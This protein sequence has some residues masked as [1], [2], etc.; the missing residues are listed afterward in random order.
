MKRFILCALLSLAATLA[1]GQTKCNSGDMNLDLKFKRAVVHNSTLA[2]D[3]VV[4]NFG[5]KDVYL[6]MRGC[7][8]YDDEGNCYKYTIRID[9]GNT[10]N[11]GCDL[12]TETP[13]KL[14]CF[15]DELDEFA[16]KIVRLDME[17]YMSGYYKMSVK[18]IAFSRD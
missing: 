4:T 16:T 17:Y 10:G 5:K 1:F 15:I 18:D 9:V 13:I 2:I 7:T 11:W 14:R 12:P 8:A 6:E 3:F